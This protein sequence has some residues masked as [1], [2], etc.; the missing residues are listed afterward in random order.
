MEPN[1]SPFTL[2]SD[3]AN[4][5]HPPALLQDT[6]LTPRHQGNFTTTRNNTV[7]TYFL[8]KQTQQEKNAITYFTRRNIFSTKLQM[9]S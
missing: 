5:G 4:Q 1:H 2:L 3:N 8:I 7:I 9:I 6:T